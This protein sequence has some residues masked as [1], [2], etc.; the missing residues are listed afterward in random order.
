MKRCCLV[1]AVLLAGSVDFAHAYYLVIKVNL[2]VTDK[3]KDEVKSKKEDHSLLS[4]R[5]ED[6]VA[7]LSLA[8]FVRRVI[9]Y[10]AVEEHRRR[11]AA[12]EVHRVH[13]A[14]L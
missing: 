12:I 4:K 1:V 3:K 11:A 10:F 6:S 8:F 2:A 5:D 14:E 13:R 9:D 7:N